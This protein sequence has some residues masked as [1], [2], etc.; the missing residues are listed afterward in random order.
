MRDDERRHA[1]ATPPCKKTSS[2]G[3]TG[4]IYTR[5][6]PADDRIAKN[7][8]GDKFELIS[9]QNTMIHVSVAEIRL[10]LNNVWEKRAKK[11][12]VFLN[13]WEVIKRAVGNDP[14]SYSKFK[15]VKSKREEKA[16][17]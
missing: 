16:N 6:C 3:L 14:V 13:L 11:L 1:T 7:W 5:R 12:K 4:E 10:V 8:F 17:I 9:Y 2:K 15:T